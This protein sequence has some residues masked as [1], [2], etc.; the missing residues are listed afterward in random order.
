MD[1]IPMAKAM[2]YAESFVSVCIAHGFNRGIGNG[3]E[4]RILF[5]NHK[6]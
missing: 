4:F 5:N 2:G 1:V 6:K 3:N